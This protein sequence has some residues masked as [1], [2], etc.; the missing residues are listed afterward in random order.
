MTDMP[1][2][3]IR[4]FLDPAALPL[5]VGMLVLVLAAAWLWFTPRPAPPQASGTEALSARI[6]A[7]EARTGPDLAPL[8]QRLAM[9]ET[10]RP[11]DL[12]SAEQR[13]AALETELGR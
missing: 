5:I 6:A 12:A 9:L 1:T 11:P 4:R 13:I 8:E 10:R 3:P 2:P 7:L